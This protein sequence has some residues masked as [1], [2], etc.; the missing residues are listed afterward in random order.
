[1]DSARRSIAA[2]SLVEPPPASLAELV[3]HIAGVGIAGVVTGLVVGGL[4]GRLFMRV[5]GALAPDFAQGVSTEA[6]NRVGEITLGGTLGLVL[7]IGI[8]A[9]ITGAVLYAVFRPWLAWAGR[10]RGVAFG[11]VLF[12]VGSATSDLLNPDNPDFFIVGNK[13]LNVAMIVA[14]FLGYGAMIDWGYGVLDRRLP[15]GDENH[16][17]ALLIYAVLTVLG[18]I[19]SASAVRLLF[20]REVCECDPP[21]LAAAFVVVAAAGTLLWWATGIWFRLKRFSTAA[22]ILGFAGLAGA[23]LFGLIRAFSDAIEVIT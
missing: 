2:R 7:F 20:T 1:M 3:R 22:Q 9:G 17:R 19:A 8:A 13:P 14:L 23:T 21:I 6:G 11:V 12:A 16:R 18:L 15:P 10:F 4:G 5:S